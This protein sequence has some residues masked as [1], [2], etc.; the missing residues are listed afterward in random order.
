MMFRRSFVDLVLVPPDENLRLYLD[1]YLSTFALLLTGAIGIHEALY[2][3]RMHG[4]NRH[5]NASVLGG[6]YNSASK[7]WA[8]IA[9][10]VLKLIHEVL[11][12]RAEA[13]LLAFGEERYEKAVTLMRGA[14]G[15]PDEPKPR[16][17]RSIFGFPNRSDPE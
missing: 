2:A 10:S 15:I 4:Q 7:P 1:F 8:P 16:P 14:L 6:P 9:N 17:W 11:K 5:S 13:F 3:Y 12:D